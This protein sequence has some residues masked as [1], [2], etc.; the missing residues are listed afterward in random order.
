MVSSSESIASTTTADNRLQLDDL[1]GPAA[2]SHQP[3]SPQRE[4]YQGLTQTPKTIPAQ[5]FYDE[6][7]SQLFEQICDLP[8]YY[9]TRTE[10]S[11]FRTC[12]DE[13]AQITGP[14]EIIELGSGSSTKTR[15]LLDAYQRLNQKHQIADLKYS[16]IDV[17]PSI[18]KLSAKQLLQDY[19][20][21]QI[22]GRVS[23]Y[24]LALA[25]LA[26]TPTTTKRLI[27]FIGSSLGNF[28]PAGCDRLLAQ[29]S[30]ALQPGD[31][32][33]LGIDLRKD[34]AILEAAYDDAQGV[35]AAFNLNMLQHL[36]N[37]FEANF[38]LTQFEHVALYNQTTH[39]IEMHLRS[40][41]PQTIRLKAINLTIEL[42]ADETILSE[43]SR[44]FDPAELQ[45]Q[46][47]NQQLHVQRIWTDPQ[48]WFGVML[49]QKQ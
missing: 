31:F 29:V 46:L 41:Q 5:Y 34:P 44:K 24:D 23:T 26:A 43:I 28:T 22:Q 3:Q 37:R 32:F 42:A 9:L 13:L 18:L 12:A 19:S 10:T 49:A 48:N 16:P 7:G 11:I 20:D 47:Q 27:G 8:E 25:Q 36:N 21:L 14:C 17:S 1:L 30:A 4:L 35:T 15:L 33:L 6:R 38:D 39:Q 40:R 2:L 45:I